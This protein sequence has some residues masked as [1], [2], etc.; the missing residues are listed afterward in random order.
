[1]LKFI[2]FGVNK[3][4][5]FGEFKE[6]NYASRLCMAVD[7]ERRG[8]I[9]F[10]PDLEPGSEIQLMRRSLD[11][12]YIRE[13]AGDL[14]KRI[15]NRKPIFA[16]YLDCAGRASAYCGTEGEEAEELQEAIGS[17]MPL[18]GMYSCVE[19]AKV[20]NDVQALDWTGVLCVFSE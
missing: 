8:L 19:I 20:G 12:Q 5:K 1:M 14:L 4:D 17:K 2:T 15:G 7:K 13:R 10:E 18:L 11:F 3:G 16:L 9:M 6:E